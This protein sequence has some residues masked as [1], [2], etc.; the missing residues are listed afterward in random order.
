MFASYGFIMW[1]MFTNNFFSSKVRIQSDRGQYVVQQGPYKFVRHP[2]YLGVLFWMPST[3][4]TMGSLWG[5]IPAALA[6][7]T[8][9][10]RTYLEDKT[11]QKELPGY[12]EYTQKVRY[13]LIPGIW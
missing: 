6:V 2:G 12:I 10:I 4:L 13:R 7:L 9:I 5:L 11:L 8:I 3:A 1:A